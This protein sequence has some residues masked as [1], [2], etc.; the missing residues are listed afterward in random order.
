MPAGGMVQK[1][2]PNGRMGQA[3]E[4]ALASVQ[5]MSSADQEIS[6][7]RDFPSLIGLLY[8]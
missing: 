5:D 8:L 2:L 7:F 6:V 4:Q 1:A 3:Q